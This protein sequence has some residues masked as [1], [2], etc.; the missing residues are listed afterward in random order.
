MLGSPW[1]PY[2]DTPNLLQPVSGQLVPLSLL[3]GQEL[4]ELQFTIVMSYSC[5]FLA[6]VIAYHL[7][8][9]IGC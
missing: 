2:M 4:R 7:Q 3:I 8:V 1:K 6:I 5:W 9:L